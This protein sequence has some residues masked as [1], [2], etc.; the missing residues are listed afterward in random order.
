MDP[1][2]DERLLANFLR[3]DRSALAELARRYE[4]PLLGLAAAVLRGRTDLARD[5]VQETWVRIIRHGHTYSARSSFKTWIYRIALN[6]CRTIAAGA[7]RSPRPP[8]D[9]DPPIDPALLA[10]DKDWLREQ[11]QAL[12]PDRRLLLLLCYHD[13]MTHRTAAQILGIPLGTL[14]SR[15]HAALTDLRQRLASEPAP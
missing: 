10:E 15:L 4:A 7:G 1:L 14:K 13:N 5:A 12:P 11:L 8:A 9:S 6:Q 2:P 3:G